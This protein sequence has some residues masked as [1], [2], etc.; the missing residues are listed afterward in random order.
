MLCMKEKK[1]KKYGFEFDINLRSGLQA[2]PLHFAVISN[3]LKNVELQIK[4]K[5]DINA[6]DK[7][8]R[9]TLHTGV[10]RMCT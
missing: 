10:I 6:I 7:L 4:M 3:H 5:A 9:T 2:T 8:G 1:L